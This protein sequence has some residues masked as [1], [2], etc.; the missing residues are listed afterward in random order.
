MLKNKLFGL[1]YRR[2]VPSL[3]FLESK[4]NCS[5]FVMI[6][7]CHGVGQLQD[8]NPELMDHGCR[9]TMLK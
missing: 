8:I 5:L 6:L 2:R 9:G 7:P 3:M 4:F 1:A